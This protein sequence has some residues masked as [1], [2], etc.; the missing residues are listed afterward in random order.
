MK[1]RS[2]DVIEEPAPPFPVLPSR[3]ETEPPAASNPSD[4]GQSGKENN[5]TERV[6][7][8]IT[9][10]QDYCGH[11]ISRRTRSRKNCDS[12][13]EWEGYERKL[14]RKAVQEKKTTENPSD[15]RNLVYYFQSLSVS[16]ET[17]LP[18]PPLFTILMPL[19]I[20]SS[21]YK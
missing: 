13:K 8:R 10:N 12:V 7:S 9:S 3:A 16:E 18:L 14:E 4:D 15:Q 17:L 5:D 1:A 2:N 6:P 21:S 20:L 19:L 11:P